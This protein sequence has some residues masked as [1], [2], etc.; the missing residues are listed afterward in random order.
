MPVRKGQ[1]IKGHFCQWGT[2]GKKYY[3]KTQRG[4]SMAYTKALKQGQAIKASQ[5]RGGNAPPPIQYFYQMIGG[6]FGPNQ[7]TEYND[8]YEKSRKNGKNSVK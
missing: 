7:K 1:D 5:Q 8:K 3:Y 2:T 6:M 4:E